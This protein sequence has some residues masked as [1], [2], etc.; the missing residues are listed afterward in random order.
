EYAQAAISLADGAGARFQ[1]AVF[2]NDLARVMFHLGE[3]GAAETLI[4]QTRAEGRA[5]K[6]QTL[7]YLT[8]L[9]E[10]E[11]AL[12]AGERSACVEHLRRM[13]AV[14]RTQR[15][16]NHTWWSSRTMARLYAEALA[17]G[18]EVEYVRGLI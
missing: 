14:G 3:R 18:V 9:V 2:R 1:A 7:E 11:I 6:A 8:F 17:H 15:F 12:Q 4:A 16:Q 5:M 10:A 13:L